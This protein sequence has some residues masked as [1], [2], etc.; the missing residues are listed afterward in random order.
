M[1]SS[2]TAPSSLDLQLTGAHLL[3]LVDE[4]TGPCVHTAPGNTRE[5]QGKVT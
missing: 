3:I 4:L 5:G 1:H 2:V